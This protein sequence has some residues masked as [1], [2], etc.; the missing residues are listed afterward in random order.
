[1]S[2]VEY[3][4]F[5]TTV[6]AYALGT[7]LSLSGIV[8]NRERWLTAAGAVC[9]FRHMHT[10]YMPTGPEFIHTVH[11]RMCGAATSQPSYCA[12]VQQLND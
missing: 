7:A 9:T 8:F 2:P 10:R 3:A 5:W 6:F 11:M 4:A 1:M 12:A